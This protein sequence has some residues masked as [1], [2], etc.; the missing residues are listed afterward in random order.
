MRRL[1]TS[2]RQFV[3]A[4]AGLPLLP[5]SRARTEM[6]DATIADDLR[7]YVG[8]G[9]KQAGG[10]GD[11]RCGAWLAGELERAGFAVERQTVSAP[12][13]TPDRAE[14][15]AGDARAILWPQPIVRPTGPEGVSGLLVRVDAAGRSA[16]S[17]RGAIALVELPFG[18]WS[19]AMARPVRAPIAAAFAGGALAAVVVTTGPTGKVIALNADGRAPMFTGPVALIAPDDAGSFLA[20]AMRGERATLW[21]TGAGGRRP[22]FNLVGRIDRGRGRWLVVSTPRSGLFTCAGE[23]GGGIAAWLHLARWASRAVNDHDLAFICNTGHEY[24]YL[25]AEQSLKAVAPKPR[26]TA[27]W[28]HLGANLAARD[29]HD[30]LGQMT[31]L[32]GADSQRYLVV[33]PPLLDAGRAEFAGLAG[34]EAPYPT[35]RITAGEL[36]GI[37]AAGYRPVAG[38]FGL[39]RFHHVVDDDIRCL[40]AGL[41]GDTAAALRAFTGHA[42]SAG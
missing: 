11:N 10:D 14:I 29:W 7:R 26:E 6:T 40:S 31:P 19:T 9:G 15:V 4:S 39:H 13:F 36:T 41:V 35:D 1:E 21:L 5:A 23:R 34:L 25:G 38:I 16:M 30:S 17:L 37:V 32:P 8:F 20:G 2:R 3:I 22:A 27:F 24:E 28:L 18:R 12:W 42:L 33:S